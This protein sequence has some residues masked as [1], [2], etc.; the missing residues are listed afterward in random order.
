VGSALARA[1]ILV[2]GQDLDHAPRALLSWMCL[3]P[4]D[5]DPEPAYFGGW[6]A[7]AVGL[8]YADASTTAARS[9]I[10]RALSALVHA[11]AVERTTTAH[12][13][14]RQAYRLWITAPA[15]SGEGTGERTPEGTGERTPEGTGERTPEGTGER[16]ERGPVSGPPIPKRPIQTQ[17][18]DPRRG[19][20]GR[21]LGRPR[22]V[23]NLDAWGDAQ[24]CD[25]GH[26]TR[27]G[28][29]RSCRTAWPAVTA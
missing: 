1:A 9:S 28:W 29:C 12:A 15:A 23:D 8:G 3:A 20:G 6:D 5:D 13:G 27:H 19:S 14:R 17:G 24:A 25:V 26:L 2:H 7:L 22:P 4:R 18:D 11:G 10:K 21:S 16:S